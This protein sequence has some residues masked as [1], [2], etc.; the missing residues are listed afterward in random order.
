[1]N[2]WQVS[3]YSPPSYVRVGYG[4]SDA[5]VPVSEDDDIW[6]R[7][8]WGFNVLHG[9]TPE[10]DT[11]THQF[12]YVAFTPSFG[13]AAVIA[14]FAR[15]N[16]Q[17]ITEDR[18]IFAVQQRALDTDYRGFSALEMHSNVAIHADRVCWLRGTFSTSACGRR[19]AVPSRKRCPRAK[20][21]ERGSR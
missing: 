10:T 3:E 16:D 1:M 11:T 19:T 7:G 12:R 15:Q 14:E 8:A 2:L 17:I 20:P 4:S 21:P 5:S 6:N 13:D 9:I 18:D